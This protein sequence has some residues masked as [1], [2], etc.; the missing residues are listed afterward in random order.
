[1]IDISGTYRKPVSDDLYR[2]RIIAAN[3]IIGVRMAMIGV[4]EE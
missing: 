1:M 3:A 4:W 2:M